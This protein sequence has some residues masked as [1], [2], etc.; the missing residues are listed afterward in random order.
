MITS[1]AFFLFQILNFFHRITGNY[2]IDIILLTLSIKIFLHPIT[3]QQ[4]R[5]SRRIQKLQPLLQQLEPLKKKDIQAYNREV[6]RLYSEHRVNPFAGCFPIFLQLPLFFALFSLLR[7][8]HINGGIFEKVTFLSMPLSQVP[9]TTLP[10]L[11]LPTTYQ[12]RTAQPGKHYFYQVFTLRNQKEESPSEKVEGWAD[13][14]IQQSLK[15]SGDLPSSGF[16][17]KFIHASDGTYRD[18]VVVVWGKEKSAVYQ[19][20]RA[21]PPE[22]EFKPI[23][24][25]PLKKNIYE[26]TSVRPGEEYVYKLKVLFLSGAQ[27]E[28]VE[29]DTGYASLDSI[30]HFT[31]SQG[32]YRD[33]LELQ[34]RHAFGAEGYRVYRGESS[35]SITVPI[36]TL[37]PQLPSGSLLFKRHQ[38]NAIFWMLIYLPAFLLVALYAFSQFFYQRQFTKLSGPRP[39]NTSPLLTPNFLT[40]MVIIVSIYFPV[41]LLLYF[42]TFSISG[43]IENEIIYT[44]LR[45][46]ERNLLSEEGNKK[47]WKKKSGS[48]PSV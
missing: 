16:Y 13:P 46:E 30:S 45:R 32:K 8:P 31:V 33:G 36:A 41:G 7:D 2:S 15:T 9:L 40:L 47:G 26:D 25:E 37:L 19:L 12:D 43:I 28:F 42:V 1:L 34:W 24:P 5:F 35:A 29:T 18:K 20:L 48:K 22:A 27:E 3:L 14:E 11:P 39:T 17:R 44:V 23:T 21:T 6:M 10:Q 38:S 4:F